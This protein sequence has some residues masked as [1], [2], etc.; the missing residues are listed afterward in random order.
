M[1]E[2][3]AGSVALIALALERARA[4]DLST[5]RNVS[6][7]AITLLTEHIVSARQRRRSELRRSADRSGREEHNV[8]REGIGQAQARRREL[9]EDPVPVVPALLAALKVAIDQRVSKADNT[10]EIPELI[11]EGLLAASDSAEAGVA[12]AL[13]AI[14]SDW[15]EIA[16]RP[17]HIIRI[18]FMCGRRAMETADGRC[19]SLVREKV[20]SLYEGSYV[21]LVRELGS[22][23]TSLACWLMPESAAR[24]YEWFHELTNAESGKGKALTA[25]CL[26]RIG[27]AALTAS[28]PS[29]AFS[30]TSTMKARG[31][32]V[33]TLESWVMSD[34]VRTHES[35]KSDLSGRYL[36]DSPADALANFFVFGKRLTTYA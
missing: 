29:I 30:A 5:S 34:E 20:R 18:L 25:V 13:S 3:T 32:D 6:R 23:L 10:G 19:L 36:G 31:L 1:D 16:G 26:C 24:F 11:V 14:P 8:L 15:S 21:D 17:E 28:M 2:T 22:E 35:I 33:S 7:D 4:Q 12:I 9:D 27:G